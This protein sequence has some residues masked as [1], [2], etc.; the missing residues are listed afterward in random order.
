MLFAALR[1][2]STRKD[3]DSKVIST[4]RSCMTPYYLESLVAELYLDEHKEKVVHQ[5]TFE[6]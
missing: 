3:S 6:S 4:D 1:S 2:F 5:S